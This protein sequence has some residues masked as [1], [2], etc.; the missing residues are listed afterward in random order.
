MILFN[1]SIDLKKWTSFD[2]I[3][4][5][6]FR[7]RNFIRSNQRIP[8]AFK[9]PPFQISKIKWSEFN[10]LQICEKFIS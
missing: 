4:L 6:I 8:K 10:V 7:R 9:Q 3:R 2:E 5:L 1:H